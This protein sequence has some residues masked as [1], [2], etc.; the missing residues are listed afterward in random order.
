MVLEVVNFSLAKFKDLE[1]EGEEISAKMMKAIE[2]KEFH[3]PVVLRRGAVDIVLGEVHRVRRGREQILGD[4]TVNI[5]GHLE[6]EIIRSES[7]KVTGV[8]PKKLVY[9][10]A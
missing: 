2:D 3:V 7:G 6:F 4:L 8:K 1:I 10:K 5:E 9:L